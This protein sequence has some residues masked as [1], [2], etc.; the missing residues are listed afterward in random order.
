MAGRVTSGPR[1]HAQA[2]TGQPGEAKVRTAG[3]SVISNSILILVK[4]IAGR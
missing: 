3:L 2:D 1:A 4:L